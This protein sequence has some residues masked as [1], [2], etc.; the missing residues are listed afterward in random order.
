M[1]LLAEILRRLASRPGL[2]SEARD[3]AA[4]MVFALREIAATVRE[5]SEAWDKR[6]YWK[7]AADLE[8]EWEWAEPAAG[9]L[10]ALIRR[11]AWELLPETLAGLYPRFSGITVAKYI[12]PESSWSGACARLRGL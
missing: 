4:E 5:A 10:E 3:M 8:L 1:R 6:G 2:D 9:R 11:E 12:F 7:K